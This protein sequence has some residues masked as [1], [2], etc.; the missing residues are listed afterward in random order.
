MSIRGRI[1]DGSVR[2]S[3]RLRWNQIRREAVREQRQGVPGRVERGGIVRDLF[4]AANHVRHPGGIGGRGWCRK[5]HRGM[6][7]HP[8]LRVRSLRSHVLVRDRRGQAAREGRVFG[9]RRRELHRTLSQKQQARRQRWCGRQFRGDDNIRC[10]CIRYRGS[11]RAAGR[12]PRLDAGQAD[13]ARTRIGM[14][15]NTPIRLSARERRGQNH[16][17]VGQVLR[18]GSVPS[19]SLFV[20]RLGA[21]GDEGQLRWRYFWRSGRKDREVRRHRRRCGA[22]HAALLGPGCQSG[23]ARLLSVG[24]QNT[25]IQLASAASTGR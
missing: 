24:G 13:V 15:E 6:P 23:F 8:I 3:R 2:S 21:R 16:R 12:K 7:I 19:Q 22:R 11:C 20:E 18:F 4:R 17:R 9:V 5:C 14:S 1:E 25:R 10:C